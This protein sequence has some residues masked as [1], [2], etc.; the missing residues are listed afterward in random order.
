MTH[1]INVEQFNPDEGRRVLVG[2]FDPSKAR[3]WEGDTYWDGHNRADVHTRDSTRSQTLYRT[4]GGRWVLRSDSRWEGE[5]TS[6]KFVTPAA[7]REWLLVND[8]DDAV[9]EL[10]GEDPAAEF[11]PSTEDPSAAGLAG[12]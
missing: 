10:C 1:M 2:R 7:A 8:D 12:H 3:S 9:A 6:W 4:A 5:Q 11:G